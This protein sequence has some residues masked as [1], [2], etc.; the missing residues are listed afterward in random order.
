MPVAAQKRKSMLPAECRNPEVVGGNRLSG[1]SQLNANIRIV[2]CSLLADVQHC[3]VG[4]QTVQPAPV[5]GPM[6][7]AGTTTTVL[8]NDNDQ[9]GHTARS[10]PNYHDAPV[11]F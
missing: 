9:G 6:A 3:A 5:P 2:T 4:D 7:G 10:H 1:L 8:P 11:V